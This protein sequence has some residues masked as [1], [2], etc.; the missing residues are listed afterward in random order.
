MVNGAVGRGNEGA[1]EGRGSETG[2]ATKGG[3]GRVRARY[4]VASTGGRGGAVDEVVE[5]LVV[6]L[7]RDLLV[8]VLPVPIHC[9]LATPGQLGGARMSSPG[10]REAE[11]LG[12]REAERLRRRRAAGSELSTEPRE[13]RREAGSE[14]LCRLSAEGRRAGSVPHN[15][16]CTNVGPLGRA[17]RITA[18]GGGNGG[19]LGAIASA[20]GGVIGGGT[21]PGAEPRGRR[22]AAAEPSPPD[23]PAPA[24][25]PDEPAP[26]A[27]PV[28]PASAPDEPAPAA[29]PVEPASTS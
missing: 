25:A 28:E 13:R 21:A 22:V 1:A 7:E 10:P 4:A 2:A 16:S 5:L 26:A 8:E 18:A 27:A 9:S 11:R 6:E 19:V 12:P 3:G 29:A 14:L 24:A 20:S 17:S 23:E 15:H